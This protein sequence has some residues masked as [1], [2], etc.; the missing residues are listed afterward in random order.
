M[1]FQDLSSLML[2]VVGLGLTFTG[3]RA[4]AYLPLIIPGGIDLFATSSQNVQ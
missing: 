2:K 3:I 1:T 4:I